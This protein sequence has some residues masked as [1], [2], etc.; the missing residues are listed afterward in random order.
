MEE[1]KKEKE[2]T[3][4]RNIEDIKTGKRETTKRRESSNIFI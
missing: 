2:K 1:R 4:N 3:S